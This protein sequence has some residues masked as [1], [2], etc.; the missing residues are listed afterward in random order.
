[1]REG[2]AER[3]P[4]LLSARTAVAARSSSLSPSPTRSSSAAAAARASRRGLPSELE[5]Q[6]DGVRAR[7]VGRERPRIVLVEQAEVPRPEP[8]QRARAEAPD[9]GAEHAGRSRGQRVEPRGHAQERRLP[10]A[11]RPEHD[12][13]LALLD[14]QGQTLQGDGRPTGRAMDAE[15]VVKVDRGA[16][17]RLQDARSGR[18]P[19]KA[20]SDVPSATAIATRATAARPRPARSQAGSKRSG[21]SGTLVRRRDAD[22][23]DDEPREEGTETGPSGEAE[24][25]EDERAGAELAAQAPR[26]D[27]LRLE[28]EEVAPLVAQLADDADPEAEDRQDESDDR[29]GARATSAVACESG[30]PDEPPLDVG[31]RR[32]GEARE[33]RAAQCGRRPPRGRV[34]AES[35]TSLGVPSPGAPASMAVDSQPASASTNGPE[36]AGTVGILAR[37]ADDPCADLRV[38]EVE[39]GLVPDAAC[40]RATSG[41]ATTGI[42]RSSVGSAGRKTS[43]RSD[44]LEGVRRCVTAPRAALTRCRSGSDQPRQPVTG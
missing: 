33:G 3:H 44:V 4:L 30:S 29:G 32:G 2:G 31:A 18:E 37:H 16:H 23:R 8:R 20:A 11:A 14:P 43:R 6:G 26:R 10:G 34:A 36:S 35:Q 41:D 19:R 39:Q 25:D 28:V 17:S 40:R 38:L 7:E 1:M 27:A 42:A 15:R 22:E 21:G 12:D 13:D 24:P 9:V 5:A